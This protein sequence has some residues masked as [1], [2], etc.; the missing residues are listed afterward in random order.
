MSIPTTAPAQRHHELL[1]GTQATALGDQATVP[2]QDGTRS[3]QPMRS[4]ASRQELDERG[5]H[6]PVSPVQPEPGIGAAQDS[7]LMPQH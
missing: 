4:Q 2:A 1:C 5:H 6:R 7:D 3:D